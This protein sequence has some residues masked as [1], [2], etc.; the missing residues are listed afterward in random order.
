ML[1]YLEVTFNWISKKI[2][3]CMC[4]FAHPQKKWV[5]QNVTTAQSRCM[6]VFTGLFFTFSCVLEKFH[7]KK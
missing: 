4:K 1:T 7:N 6:Q 3:A 5:G 2:R